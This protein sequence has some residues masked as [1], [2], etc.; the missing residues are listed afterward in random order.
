MSRRAQGLLVAALVWSAMLLAWRQLDAQSMSAS[1]GGPRAASINTWSAANTFTSSPVAIGNNASGTQYL[2]FDGN[3]TDPQIGYDSAIPNQFV[4]SGTQVAVRGVTN[5]SS[6][7]N[8][9]RADSAFLGSLAVPSLGGD[10]GNVF[11]NPQTQSAA[12]ISAANVSE[13]RGANTQ[14]IDQR[15]TS[16]AIT[17]TSG[18]TCT[19]S[20]L[21]AN[22]A[23]V[24]GVTS[25]VT[26]AVAGC[27]T[28]SV[29]DGVT[30]NLWSNAT[31]VTLGSVT[32]MANFLA[33]SPPPKFYTAAN[34]VVVT[35]NGGTFSA[36]VI[37][38]SAYTVDLTAS[39]S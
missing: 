30:A 26:T 36:G 13:Q 33:A 35:C 27:T 28:I 2:K 10:A 3:G 20:N 37:R 29:G 25:R 24:Y 4:V 5:G 17:C 9:Y 6:T 38:L 32:N 23:L 16:A 39:S 12:V 34:N 8:F 7:Y 14:K 22:A 19:A 21:I 11:L 15:I 1:A 31:A 18:A